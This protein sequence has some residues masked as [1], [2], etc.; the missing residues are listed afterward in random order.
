MAQTNLKN[1]TIVVAGDITIDWNIASRHGLDNKNYDFSRD[2][3]ARAYKQRGGAFLLADLIKAIT[4]SSSQE[5]EYNVFQINPPTDTILPSDNRFHHAYALWSL[6]KEKGEEIW[7]LADQLG[8]DQRPGDAPAFGDWN[9]VEKDP[10]EADLII[11]NDEGLGFR[12]CRDLWPK[13]LTARKAK[14]WVLLKMAHPVAQ[15]ELWDYLQN[16]HADR[17]IVVTTSKNLRQTEVQVSQGISWERTAQD[18]AWELIYNPQVNSFS[19]CAAVIISFDTAGAFLLS[20]LEGDATQV[21][22]E[23]NYPQY[24]LFFDPM[25]IEGMWKQAHPGG[26][27]GYTTCLT[28]GIAHQMLNTLDQP[29]IQAGIQA[30]LGAM[31]KLHLKGYRLQ[32]V[33]EG[34]QLT[35][36]VEEIAEELKRDDSPFSVVDVQ[37][38][39]EHLIKPAGEAGDREE[40]WWTIL[41]DQHRDHL[42]ILAEEIVL[43][44]AESALNDVPQGNFGHMLTV[45]RRE[46]ESYR[47]IYAF[48][49][50][51]HIGQ[52]GKPLS[53][54]VF[55]APGSGK[56]FGITQVAQSLAPGMIEPLQFNLS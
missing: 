6:F 39:F 13:A 46:I 45:D 2:I 43:N 30:G 29:N 24:R 27:T 28:A 20:R 31:R 1:Q 19:H 7:R 49:E 51:L 42:D 32:E 53:L 12:D 33:A 21:V 55:G 50:D 41:E 54:A 10:T 36:P 15:G 48:A 37:G 16:H 47:S 22:G 56:S 34:T 8:F 35:F 26:M 25:V 44:G 38:P 17:L 5:V 3:W 23:S 4:S 11:L 52:S 40:R 18:V 9:Q 14:P